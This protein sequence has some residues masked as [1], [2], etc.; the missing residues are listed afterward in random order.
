MILIPPGCRFSGYAAERSAHIF[1]HFSLI[2]V[3]GAALSFAYA[4]PVLPESAD[5]MLTAFADIYKR[6]SENADAYSLQLGLVCRLLLA[7]LLH[8]QK[9]YR[10]TSAQMQN[11]SIPED[12][13]NAA[14]YVT[15]H[16]SSPLSA[17]ELADAVSMNP[18][19][20]SR[21][22]QKYIG[23]TPSRYITQIKMEYAQ[24]KLL[25]SDISV[26]ALSEEL[27]FPDPFTFS[28]KFKA[29]CGASPTEYRKLNI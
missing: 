28:K 26:K 21:R 14:N 10:H 8:A 17:A 19:Y 1:C 15:A 23:M 6:Y 24:K 9:S 12:I 3:N 29:T 11:R 25:T 7:E 4:R 18:V 13:L 27:G 5:A 22:F 16:L 2:D 20:F